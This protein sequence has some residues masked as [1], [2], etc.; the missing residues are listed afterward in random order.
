MYPAE[1]PKHML[2]DPLRGGEIKVFE[3]L[4]KL[5][6]GF[7]VFYNG[8][9]RAG[10]FIEAHE[11]PVD[12]IL[13]HEKWML[14]IEVKGGQVRVGE[15]GLIEHFIP[16]KRHWQRINPVQQVK[17][18]LFKLIDACRADGINYWIPDDCCVVF[19]DTRRGQFTAQQHLIPEGFFFAEDLDTLPASFP[20]FLS[21]KYQRAG[22]AWREPEAFDYMVQRLAVGFFLKQPHKP[23]PPN[24]PASNLK[25]TGWDD[26]D[27]LQ[28]VHRSCREQAH[29]R[30]FGDFA[31]SACHE[32]A[33][34]EISIYCTKCGRPFSVAPNC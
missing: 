31:C 17:V 27:A 32:P 8:A 10:Q 7:H 16:R 2:S 11:R 14:C 6:E 30:R 29:G 24:S 13:L 9:L 18:A 26:L 4:E 23:P 34:S 21:E 20:R 19:P 28:T 1:S 33:Y 22:R 3:A 5:P 12:F 15:S 25:E